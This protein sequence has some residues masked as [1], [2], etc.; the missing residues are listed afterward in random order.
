MTTTIQLQAAIEVLRQP[1]VDR[2]REFYTDLRGIT[3][4]DDSGGESIESF[5]D[6]TAVHYFLRWMDQQRKARQAERLVVIN[7]SQIKLLKGG[8]RHGK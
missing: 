3:L 4:I 1:I 8:R 6:A 7:R 2:P 5:E